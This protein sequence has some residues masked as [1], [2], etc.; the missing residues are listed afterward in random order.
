MKNKVVYTNIFDSPADIIVNPVNTKGVTGKGLAL[1]YSKRYPSANVKYKAACKSKTLKIGT[2]QL[3]RDGGKS[4]LL[5]PTKEEWRYNSKMEYIRAGL[6]KIVEARDRF[7]GKVISFPKLG[8]GAGR[9]DWDKVKSLIIEI[10]KPLDIEIL[11]H[12]PKVFT[13]Y[14]ARVKHVEEKGITPV[15]IS[16]VTPKWLPDIKRDINLA[17]SSNLLFKYKEGNMSE[18]DYEKIYRKETLS[19]LDQHNVFS[20][21]AG[22]CV[23][24]YEK[25]VDFCHRQIFA[26]WMGEAGFEV[27]EIK[28]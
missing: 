16:R 17:P 12:E 11:F 24:C 4:I 3:V 7:E 25:S 26:R 10:L 1:E 28:F 9:L 20:A 22:E 21:H 27:E 23:M 15:S 5:F 8:S 18:E 2:L 13:S 19:K 6:N 14:F